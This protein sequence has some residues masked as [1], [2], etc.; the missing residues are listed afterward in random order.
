MFERRIPGRADAQGSEATMKLENSNNDDAT[1]LDGDGSAVVDAIARSHSCM[2][3]LK[4]L[5]DAV[6]RE[7]DNSMKAV[8]LTHSQMGVIVCLENHEGG[9]CSFKE[10]Q[11]FLRVSQPTTTGLISRL[12]QKGFVTTLSSATDQ[13][14]KNVKLTP[15]GWE[16][17]GAGKRRFDESQDK[18]EAGIDD[19]EMLEVKRCLVLM[20]ANLSDDHDDIEAAIVREERMCECPSDSRA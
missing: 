12:E 11:R 2:F 3:L 16:A 18:M 8:G 5:G 10:V 7:G 9:E 14:A 6:R 15:K 13:R 4:V 17:A 19:E 1:L 20:I